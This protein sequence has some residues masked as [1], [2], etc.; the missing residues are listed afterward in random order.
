MRSSCKAFFELVIK[1]GGS[2][3]SG[4]NPGLVVFDF[5]R[6]QVEQAMANKPVSNIPP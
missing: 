1:V 5:I 2:I 3:V 6:K 4:A